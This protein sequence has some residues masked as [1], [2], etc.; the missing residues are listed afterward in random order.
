MS[1][2]S[3][4]NL[5]AKSRLLLWDIDG[6]LLEINK[7]KVDRHLNAINT[8][9][10]VEYSGISK[11]SGMT[12]LEIVKEI[13]K[14]NCRELTKKEISYIFKDLDNQ[15]IKELSGRPLKKNKYIIPA[16][17]AISLLKITNGILTGNSKNRAIIKIQSSGLLSYFNF[18]YA[19]FGGTAPNRMYLVQ[20]CIESLGKHSDTKITIIGDSPR[21]IEAAAKFGINVIAIATGKHSY[22]DLLKFNPTLTLHDLKMDFDILMNYLRDFAK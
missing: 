8:V 2:K 12:D 20:K 5:P 19:Y 21:D 14:N 10:N 9:L 22:E 16:L 7:S 6:T 1:K 11:S 3:D 4:N 15:T 17:N 13:A 18:N